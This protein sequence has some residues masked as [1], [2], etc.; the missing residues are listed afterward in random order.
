MYGVVARRRGVS[1]GRRCGGSAVEV[2]VGAGRGAADVARRVARQEEDAGHG[3][4]FGL[5][6]PQ[7]QAGNLAVIR[8]PLLAQRRL[9]A[10]EADKLS[11]MDGRYLAVLDEMRSS[12]VRVANARDKIARADVSAWHAER[13]LP[14]LLADYERLTGIVS[15]ENRPLITKVFSVL[16]EALDGYLTATVGADWLEE[17]VALHKQRGR[18]RDRYSRSDPAISLS[19]CT[20]AT[21]GSTSL[22][23]TGHKR[24][25]V[26]EMIN[27]RNEFAHH[28][29]MTLPDMYRLVDTSVLLANEINSTSADTLQ[30]LRSSLLFQMSMVDAEPIHIDAQVTE[31]IDE[32][33]VL[34]G[35]LAST[36]DGTEI[37][38]PIPPWSAPFDPVKKVQVGDRITVDVAGNLDPLDGRY[39]PPYA[40]WRH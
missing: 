30:K 2:R 16:G 38:V 14:D 20:H 32:F 15:L 31:L 28:E 6:D 1:P 26:Y 21:L 22:A 10:S 9:P 33:G 8:S 24:N 19:A 27:W 37:K 11:D 12:R 5:G 13:E 39:I 23:F 36:L 29:V 40:I 18:Q 34:V 3:V 4:L 25:W 17:V 35:V 7:E